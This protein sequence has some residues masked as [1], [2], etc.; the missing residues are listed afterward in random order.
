MKTPNKKAQFILIMALS[1]IMLMVTAYTLFF[2]INRVQHSL[3]QAP[4]EPIITVISSDFERAALNG[5]RYASNYYYTNSNLTEARIA[6]SK[7]ITQWAATVLQTYSDV[8]LELWVGLDEDI[9]CLLYTSPSP[10][11]S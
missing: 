1:L 4:T 8:G 3:Q 7:Y 10:R 11:D 9:I 5:L 2:T 6:F